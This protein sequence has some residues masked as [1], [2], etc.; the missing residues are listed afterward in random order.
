MQKK[1]DPCRIE[2]DPCQFARPVLK[3]SETRASQ[4]MDTVRVEQHAP[5]Y[6][7]NQRTRLANTPRAEDPCDANQRTRSV[8]R[9]VLNSFLSCT[10]R[11]ADSCV[12]EITHTPHSHGPCA[13]PCSSFSSASW[14]SPHSRTQV[15][16]QKSNAASPKTNHCQNYSNS[17]INSL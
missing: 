4:I 16:T 13:D 2:N 15:F 12:E 9:P 10:V 17:S 1:L 7:E 6:T 3:P 5:C 11:A 8:P 14:S